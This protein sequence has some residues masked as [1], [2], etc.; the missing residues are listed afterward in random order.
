MFTH[1]DES[2]HRVTRDLKFEDWG[3]FLVVWRMDRIEVY[4]NYVGHIYESILTQSTH[5]F[6]LYP[7]KNGLQVINTLLSSSL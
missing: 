5:R 3:E 6:R 1:F 4:E 2:I 7:V